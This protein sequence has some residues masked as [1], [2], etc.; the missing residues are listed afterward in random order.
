M[1]YKLFHTKCLLQKYFILKSR[2]LY[3]KGKICAYVYR[4]L[5]EFFRYFL[6]ILIVYEIL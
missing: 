1:K 6:S 2:F 4:K 3:K 5:Y